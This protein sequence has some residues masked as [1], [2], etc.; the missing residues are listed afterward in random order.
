LKGIFIYD[1]IVSPM[2]QYSSQYNQVWRRG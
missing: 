1:I 2:L